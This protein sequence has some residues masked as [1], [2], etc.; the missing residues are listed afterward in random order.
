M[1]DAELD[2]LRRLLRGVSD[3]FDEQGP[4]AFAFG[5]VASRWGIV[6]GDGDGPRPFLV[7]LAGQ[8]FRNQNR[9]DAEHE[10]T[11]L[12][13]YIGFTPAHDVGVSARCDDPVD[14]AVTALLA[15]EVTDIVGGVASMETHG[16]HAAITRTLSGAMARTTDPWDI[17]FGSSEL[18]RAWAA[19][20]EFRLLK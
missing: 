20:P 1:T 13:P 4:G 10:D 11:G 8:G 5:V 16:R 3:R 6:D 17:T 14:H 2:R 19:H 15:A 18:L 12:R 9:F 7:Q